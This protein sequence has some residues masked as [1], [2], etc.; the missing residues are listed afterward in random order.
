ML[1]YSEIQ[2]LEH[3]L[4]RVIFNGLKIWQDDKHDWDRSKKNYSHAGK[5]GKKNLKDPYRM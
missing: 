2:S 4:E 1:L 5:N 3:D